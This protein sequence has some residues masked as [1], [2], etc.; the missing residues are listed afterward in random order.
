MIT[1]ILL[2]AGESKR[3]PSENKL[4]KSFKGKP[5]I[6]HIL[7]SLI[8]SKVNKIVIVLGCDRI[9]IKKI[10]LKSKKITLTINMLRQVLDFYHFHFH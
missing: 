10:L 5:L 8:K 6:N 2:A 3:V 1:A 4:I 9:K 7:K